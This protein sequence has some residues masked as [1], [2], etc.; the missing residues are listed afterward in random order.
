MVSSWQSCVATGLL[1]HLGLVS[2]SVMKKAELWTVVDLLTHSILEY[3]VGKTT[4]DDRKVMSLRRTGISES[5]RSFPCG[6][7]AEGEMLL[8]YLI[9]L[10]CC[11]C[12]LC[13]SFCI[14]FPVQ[15]P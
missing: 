10:L 7:S 12:V 6:L 2:F 11:S 1:V 5:D 14:Y 15:C 4:N 13:I 3:L 9:L 8:M